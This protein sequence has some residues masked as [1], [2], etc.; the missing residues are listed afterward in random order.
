MLHHQLCG[1]LGIRRV[2]LGARGR[3]GFSVLGQSYRVNGKEDE[4]VV[5]QESKD[6][7][8]S[9]LLNVATFRSTLHDSYRRPGGMHSQMM[10]GSQYVDLIRGMRKLEL[11]HG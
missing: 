9:R 8:A 1:V 5:L 7:R 10:N 2:I 6:Q 3:E 11:P 4:E